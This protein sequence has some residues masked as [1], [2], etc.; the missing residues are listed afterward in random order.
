[1]MYYIP[2]KVQNGSATPRIARI[3]PSSSMYIHD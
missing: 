1:L 2:N 3:K